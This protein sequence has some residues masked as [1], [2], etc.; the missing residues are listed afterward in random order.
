MLACSNMENYILS[1]HSEILDDALIGCYRQRNLNEYMALFANSPK[2]RT[3]RDEI[4]EKI[5]EKGRDNNRWNFRSKVA[6]TMMHYTPWLFRIVYKLYMP[7]R[8]LVC[9]VTGR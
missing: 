7:C 4:R 1:H 3:L 8:L 5:L 2:N 6:Y 9:K